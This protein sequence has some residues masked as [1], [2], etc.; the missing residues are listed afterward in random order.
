MS[1]RSDE[2]ALTREHRKLLKRRR[3]AYEKK[4]FSLAARLGIKARRAKQKAQGVHKQR[5]G[6][7]RPSMLDGHP[8]DVAD[9]VKRFIALA[10][11]WADDNGAVCTVTATTDGSHATGSWHYILHGRNEL[12]FAVDLIFATVGQMEEFQSWVAE[13]TGHGYSDWLELFGP[14]GFYVKS[15]VRYTGHFP[16]HGDHLHGAPTQSYRR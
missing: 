2:R 4:H 11:R 13:K 5:V 10:Y 15:G 14:A 6:T 7:F 3:K 16:D 1:L 9:Q 12:G 8:G